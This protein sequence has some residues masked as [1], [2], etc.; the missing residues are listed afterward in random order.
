MPLNNDI[1]NTVDL[2][3]KGGIVAPSGNDPMQGLQ[4]VNLDPG[5]T[6]YYPID[7]PL[8]AMTPK[9]VDGFASLNYWKQFTKLNIKRKQIGVPEGERGEASY[10]VEQTFSGKYG[11]ISQDGFVTYEAQM[12]ATNFLELVADNQS[13]NVLA[14]KVQEERV[15]Y[16]GNATVGLSKPVAPVLSSSATGGSLTG[17][18]S[19][20]VVALTHKAYSNVYDPAQGKVGVTKD[21]TQLAPIYTFTPRFSD[22]VYTVNMGTS[23]ASDNTSI[24]LTGS[25]ASISASVKTI[26]GAAGYAWFIGVKGSES[27]IDVTYL[28]SIVIT[29]L[30]NTTVIAN[31]NYVNVP[32]NLFVNDN[33]KDVFV[34]DGII[35]QITKA[36]S[37]ATIKALDTGVAGVGTTLTADGSGGILEIE[38]FLSTMYRNT[39]L[40]PDTMVLSHKVYAKIKQIIGAN[41]GNPLIRYEFE[42]SKGNQLVA[43]FQ[44]IGY[45]STNTGKIIKMIQ[46]VDATEGSILFITSQ[47]NYPVSNNGNTF[48]LSARKDYY[49]L[50]YGLTSRKYEFGIYIDEM[51]KIYFPPAFGYMYNIA[52]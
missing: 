52:V 37:G 27:L 7:T 33:S 24:T 42:A 5:I 21:L 23:V 46:H 19:V 30:P 3:A 44:V 8:L 6:N 28:N 10:A 41:G 2:L 9:K 48:E 20:I 32:A 51:L 4:G 45:T 17:S 14:L 36:G 26:D 38:E 50:T 11:N 31:S 40:V 18:L 13:K 34:F 1:Q 12:A 43:G 49:S 15:L 47:V 22:T 29:D 35:P 25:T 39:R 16:A